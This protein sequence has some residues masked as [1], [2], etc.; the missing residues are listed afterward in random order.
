MQSPRLRRTKA[1]VD[2][3]IEEDRGEELG[4]KM[5]S[6][7]RLGMGHGQCVTCEIRAL[8]YLSSSLSYIQH[9]NLIRRA[10]PRPTSHRSVS[11]R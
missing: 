5:R 10:K 11:S 8:G 6:P 4:G 9:V 1:R 7:F 2:R 3:P